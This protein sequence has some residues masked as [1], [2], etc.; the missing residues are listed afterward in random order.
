[1]TVFVQLGENAGKIGSLITQ[2]GESAQ[3]RLWP[4]PTGRV[5]LNQRNAILI[6]VLG[7]QHVLS[8]LV[9]DV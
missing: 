1:V 6:G 7:L 5:R 3:S 9:R 2:S 4:V 8:E